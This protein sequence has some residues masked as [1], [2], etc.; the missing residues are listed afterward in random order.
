LPRIC[1]VSASR[2]D[3][4][5]LMMPNLLQYPVAMFVALRAGLTVPQHVEFRAELPKT[6]VGRI[7]RRELARQEA[8]AARAA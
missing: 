8:G 4:V 5:A 2:G 1:S 6:N 3:R 7:L